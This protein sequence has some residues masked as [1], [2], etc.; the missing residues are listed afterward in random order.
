M[1]LTVN[2]EIK[3][4]KTDLDSITLDLVLKKLNYQT[5]LI[6]VEFNGLIIEP[7]KWA[8]QKVTDEDKLEIVTIVGGGSYS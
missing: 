8:T 1:R 5:Q 4:I 6:V 2:G 3:I 7:K